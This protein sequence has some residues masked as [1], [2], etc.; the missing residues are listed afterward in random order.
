MY[1]TYLDTAAAGIVSERS[2]QA[3]RKYDQLLRTAPSSAFFSFLE[4]DYRRI[5]KSV[6]EFCGVD[7]H[8][9]AFIPNFSYGLFAILPSLR[10]KHKRV[11]LL[12][13]DY[14]SLTLPF[15]LHDFEVQW[16]KSYDGFNWLPENIEQA[17]KKDRIEILAISHVQYLTGALLDLSTIAEICKRNGV[18]LIVDATQSIGAMPIHFDHLGIDVLITSNYKWM[19]G[20]F[21]SGLMCF[22]SGY[23]EE[24]PPK[25]GGF[26]SLKNMEG[27]WKYV[28]SSASFQPGHFNFSSLLV[29]EQAL[30]EKNEIGLN[31]IEAHN[32][33]LALKFVV[34]IIES[35]Q[36]IIGPTTMT[37]RSSIVCIEASKKLH[38][39]FEQSMIRCTYRN[40]SIRFAFHFSN[41]NEDVVKGLQV[42]KEF[43]G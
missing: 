17:I 21:G 25:I 16:A 12:A 34:G 23:F 11:L 13:N 19:N 33:E 10:A 43:N 15:E 35:N 6:A 36:H 4:K 5:K 38:R 20:G 1:T 28:P 42:L 8:H 3:S 14:P 39:A 24:Y 2:L 9:L 29:L 30:K 27:E 22:R 40:N 32:H 37:G 7:T 26:G 41:S 31:K 18:F